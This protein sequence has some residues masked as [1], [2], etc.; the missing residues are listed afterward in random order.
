MEL[1]SQT[2]RLKLLHDLKRIAQEYNKLDKALHHLIDDL[3]K[4][5]EELNDGK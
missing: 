5:P 4:V 2:T 1:V 3:D